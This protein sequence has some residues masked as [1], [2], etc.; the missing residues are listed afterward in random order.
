M[1][2]RSPR[3]HQDNRAEGSK[4]QHGLKWKQALGATER[5]ELGALVEL[6]WY[7]KSRAGR[8]RHTWRCR[9]VSIRGPE[10]EVWT[11]LTNLGEEEWSAGALLNA[12]APRLPSS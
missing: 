7:T 8:V 9:A 6:A 12:I 10:G 11:Y 3:V 1:Q 2:H 4:W 5:A